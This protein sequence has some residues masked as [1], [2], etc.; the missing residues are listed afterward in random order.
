MKTGRLRPVKCLILLD[1]VTFIATLAYAE[2]RNAT[3]SLATTEAPAF[4]ASSAEL[5][6]GINPGKTSAAAWFEWGTTASL[7]NRTETRPVGDGTTT[8]NVSQ[9][10]LIVPQFAIAGGGVTQP[11]VNNT[12]TKTLN[13]HIDL[14]DT[15]GNPMGVN[16]NG[17]TRST[18]TYSI[19][20]GGT[21][22][23]APRDSNGQSPL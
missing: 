2:T 23:L 1:I 20:V 15:M 22:V 14:F 4:T 7:P 12:T 16:L 17:Q 9:S 13:R 19:P 21:F 11:T 5:H 3:F 18:F 10:A 8:L 6:G